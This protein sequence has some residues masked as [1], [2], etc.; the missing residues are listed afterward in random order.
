MKQKL[1]ISNLAYCLIQFFVKV[2]K[3]LLYSQYSNKQGIVEYILNE[4]KGY[5]ST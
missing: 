3:A 1:K 2:N 4:L 5:N